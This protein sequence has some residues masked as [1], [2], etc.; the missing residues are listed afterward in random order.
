MIVIVI[1]YEK[2]IDVLFKLMDMMVFYDVIIVV[3][4]V[5]GVI[6]LDEVLKK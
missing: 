3:G 1:K 2:Y 4:L 6:V 5:K